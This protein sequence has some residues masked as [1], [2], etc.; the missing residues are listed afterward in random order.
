LEDRCPDEIEHPFSGAG[1][2]ALRANFE[3]LRAG[4]SGGA[5]GS[6]GFLAVVREVGR[7][8]LAANMQSL[9]DQ[10]DATLKEIEAAG[11]LRAQVVAADKTRCLDENSPVPLCRLYFQLKNFSTL[12]RTDF[13]TALNLN[14][15]RTEADND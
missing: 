14:P 8:E 1:I 6:V 5:N 10:M 2:E 4:M 13:M 7:G 12:Y 11:D 3:A 15:P 9:I